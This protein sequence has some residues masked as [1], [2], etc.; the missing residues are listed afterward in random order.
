MQEQ[1]S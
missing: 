1:P